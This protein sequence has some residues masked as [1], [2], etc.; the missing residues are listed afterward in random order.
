MSVLRAGTELFHGTNCDEFDEA[1]DVLCGPAWL[2]RSPQV[3]QYF[4]TRSGGRGGQARV[5]R[6]VLG[7]DISLPEIT[8]PNDLAE[9]AE[10]YSLELTGVEEMRSSIEASGLPGWVIPNNYPEGDDILLVD[11]RT[12]HY[13]GTTPC[14]RHGG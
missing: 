5:I 1:N 7:E 12:L 4:A 14:T 10:A 9:L 13:V 3:A 8:S 6:Y 11:T 2:S